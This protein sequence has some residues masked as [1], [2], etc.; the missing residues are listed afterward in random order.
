MQMTL[1]TV[2][3]KWYPGLALFSI[4]IQIGGMIMLLLMKILAELPDIRDF[5]DC[6]LP[7]DHH[8]T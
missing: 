5:S 2:K 1:L 6:D 8:L 4:V 7:A 3:A